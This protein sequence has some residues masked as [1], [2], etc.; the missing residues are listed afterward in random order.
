MRRVPPQIHNTALVSLDLSNV[1]LGKFPLQLVR[2]RTLVTPILYD[3]RHADW[4]LPAG[5]PRARDG[6][7][8]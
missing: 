7:G 4:E 5:P 6:L 8:G 1:G 3:A 2:A